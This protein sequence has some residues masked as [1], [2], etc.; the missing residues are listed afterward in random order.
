[1]DRIEFHGLTLSARNGAALSFRPHGKELLRPAREL[2]TLQLLDPE[3]TP[4]RVCSSDFA[5]PQEFGELTLVFAGTR[6]F[7]RL[8]VT[9][10]LRGESD[11]TVAFRFEVRGIESGWRLEWI[12]APQPV[13]GAGQ[14]LFS[15]VSE[16]MLVTDF[17]LRRNDSYSRYHELGF[18]IRGRSTGNLYPG[19]AQMQFLAAYDAKGDGVYFGADDPFHTPKAVEYE[20][21]DGGDARLSL[22]TFCG[23]GEPDRYRSFEYRLTPFRGDWKNACECYRNWIYSLPEFRKKPVRPA[24]MRDSPVTL[25]YAV[26]GDGDDRG[27]L[28]ANLYF[29]YEN[30]LPV[31]DF[32]A[33]A[34]DSRILALP[35]HWEG[36]APWAPPYVW[37]PYGGEESF[38]RFRDGLHE[39]GH[40]LGVYCSGTAW[41]QT[42]SITSYSQEEKFA[43]EGL[44]REMMR[45][46]RGEIDAVVCNGENLQRLGYDL[47][48]AREW[49]RRTVLDEFGKLAAF[50]LDY[51]QFFDQNIGGGTLLCYSR[52]HGHPEIP[53][54]WQ[55]RAMASL[56]RE[57]LDAAG[58]KSPVIGAEASAATPYV[59]NLIYNDARACFTFGRGL[60]VPG[61]AYVFHEFLCNFM[62]NQCG[63]HDHFDMKKTPW[64]L[65]YRTAYAFHCGD[66]LS[67][68]LGPG[69][70][71]FWN[72]GLKWGAAPLPPQ[73]QE[74]RL[75]HSLNRLRK[76]YPQFLFEGRMIPEFIRWETDSVPLELANRTERIPRILASAWEDSA[77]NRIE[78]LTNFL[79]DPCEVVLDGTERRRLEGLD[80]LV[81]R[82]MRKAESEPACLNAE[83]S[84][85]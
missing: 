30:A 75:L 76:Q 26:R 18:P 17:S 66:M 37:P 40:L 35:M 39:R 1:M 28:P 52:E 32:Y 4:R 74:L 46:P 60:P 21:L 69:G 8:H 23:D 64:N 14:T 5:A 79:P 73:E 11:G 54:A 42:S 27:N 51:V 81:L 72:W 25:I 85:T 10:C 33:E 36:T 65:F 31:A 29:P 59:Q 63:I 50:G 13:I 6:Q 2:F 56:Q 78:F 47:C 22:Q 70:K 9:A 19:S 7:P 82:P 49:S 62:G 43:A 57:M 77:G 53:G 67:I 20:P 71:I 45:G 16:G 24:W 41:T 48:V 44:E 12:D 84:Y 80:T 61:Y 83:C 55:T 38:A 15:P 58:E 34:L 3:R 68:L